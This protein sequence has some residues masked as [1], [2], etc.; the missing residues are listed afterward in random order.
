M[1]GGEV[2]GWGGGGE[3]ET[4]RQTE[5]QG[6]KV[7]FRDMGQLTEYG[8]FGRCGRITSVLQTTW[9]PHD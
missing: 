5:T 9:C 6:E 3:T 2:G 4:E 8:F 7:P 1:G